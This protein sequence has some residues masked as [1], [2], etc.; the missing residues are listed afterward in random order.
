VAPTDALDRPPSWSTAIRSRGWSPAAA[1]ARSVL[2]KLDQSGRRG[3]VLAEQDHATDLAATDPIEQAGARR[4]PCIRTI[5]FWPMSW[6][7]SSAPKARA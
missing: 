1:P 4:E 7:G 5:S 2:D 6:R 3:D